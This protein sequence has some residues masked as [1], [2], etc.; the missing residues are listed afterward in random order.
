M[1]E[2]TRRD[3]EILE[4]LRENKP[5]SEGNK[6]ESIAPVKDGDLPLG[7]K[8]SMSVRTI[9]SAGI[10][11]LWDTKTFEKVPILYYMANQKMKEK[12]TDGSYRWTAREPDGKPWKGTIKCR[13]HKEDADRKF[14]DT[15]G[16]RYCNKSNLANVYE[17]DRHMKMKHPKEWESI[18]SA[19]KEQERTEDREL[20]RAYLRA[21]GEHKEEPARELYV[22]DKDKKH[23]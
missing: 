7:E 1:T 17:R 2:A 18:E 11:H 21:I 23:K 22:S 9:S 3:A 14:Y 19:R 4:V 16:L 20:Q 15:L 6:E 8:D 5:V 10:V 12:R 13:L